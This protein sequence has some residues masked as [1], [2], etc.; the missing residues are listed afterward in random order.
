MTTVNTLYVT[1]PSSTLSENSG[2]ERID[3]TSNTPGYFISPEALFVLSLFLVLSG[4]S[5]ISNP[6]RLQCCRCWRMGV[7]P[8]WLVCL[9]MVVVQVSYWTFQTETH[10]LRHMVCMVVQQKLTFC[11]VPLAPDIHV[12]TC[13]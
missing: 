2:Q 10:C 3:S 5:V 8:V 7:P 9:G 6:R 12:H 13:I 4:M 1:T 11:K